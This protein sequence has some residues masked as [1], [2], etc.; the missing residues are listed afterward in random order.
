MGRFPHAAGVGVGWGSGIIAQYLPG[1]LTSGEDL[2][3][4]Q[5]WRQG[6]IKISAHGLASS[7]GGTLSTKHNSHQ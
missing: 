2:G 1:M 7:P 6:G 4:Q 5:L 3:P